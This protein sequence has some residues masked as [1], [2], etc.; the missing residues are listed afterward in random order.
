MLLWAVSKPLQPAAGARQRSRRTW[1]KHGERSPRARGECGTAST[2]AFVQRQGR[3]REQDAEHPRAPAQGCC[4]EPAHAGGGGSA[5]ASAS[6]TPAARNRAPAH[7]PTHTSS[8][9]RFVALLVRVD[10]QLAVDL[11]QRGN[12]SRWTSCCLNVSATRPAPWRHQPTAAGRPASLCR[13]SGS[14]VRSIWPLAQGARA[15]GQG[16]RQIQP[17]SANRS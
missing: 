7:R 3:D 15:R 9:R 6:S 17:D 11:D 13:R 16:L 5:A 8:D 12:Q 14:A 4:V 1:H 2:T 10:E